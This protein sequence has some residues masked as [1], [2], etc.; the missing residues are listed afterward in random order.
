M[1]KRLPAR[2]RVLDD[3]PPVYH[4]YALFG[5]SNEQLP[6]MYALNQKSKQPIILAYIQFA[7]AKCRERSDDQVSFA[8]LFCADGYFAM[9]ALHL[10]ATSSY[11]VDTNRDGQSDALEDIA[12]RLG[13]DVHL[14]KL[15]VSEI[16][17][18][19]PV[20]IVANVGGLYHV[21]NP[22]DILEKSYRHAKRYLIVQ[23]VV[24][25]E[26]N[27]P[28]YFESPAPGWKWGSRYSRASFERLLASK[29]WKVIDTHFNFLEGNSRQA[30]MGS[31][32]ALVEK[33]RA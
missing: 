9:S 26:N 8:E 1:S 28:D 3:L 23:N 29:G 31:C 21:E 20:D 27:D 11:G 16:D 15:N 7:I 32:Y 13:L 2:L 22:D 19:E 18:L 24:S 12:R 4:S 17:Q 33:P 6:G 14:K 5:V 30:D 25:T 10:G